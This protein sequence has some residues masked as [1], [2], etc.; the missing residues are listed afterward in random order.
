[1][2]VIPEEFIKNPDG[3][4]RALKFANVNGNYIAADLTL[5]PV[6]VFQT[7]TLE[8]AFHRM[9]EHHLSGLPVVDEHYHV[10]GFVT[11]IELMAVCYPSSEEEM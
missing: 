8:N 7:D 9:N 1:M 6:Y 4:Q 2:P 10:T 5:E 3:Y 11:L